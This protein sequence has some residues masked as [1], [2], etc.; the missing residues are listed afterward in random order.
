MMLGQNSWVFIVF[1]TVTPSIRKS[2]GCPKN[3]L[4]KCVLNVVYFKKFCKIWTFMVVMCSSY[5]GESVDIKFLIVGAV[6]MKLL[7]IKGN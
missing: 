4:Q 7:K 1:S 6:A 3:G 2:R 5:C